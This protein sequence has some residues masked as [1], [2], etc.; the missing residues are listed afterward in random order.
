MKYRINIYSN[1]ILKNFL[2]NF[3]FEYELKFKKLDSIDKKQTNIF[4]NVII[5][6]NNK[7]LDLINFNK[8]GDNFLVISNSKKINS[9]QTKNTKFINSPISINHIRNTIENFIQNLKIK[10]HDICIDNEKLINLNNKFHC[11]LTKVEIEILSFLI[12]EKETS[13]NFIKENILK[14]K[15]DI[16][17][18]SLE[19]HLTRIRKKMI[20]IKTTVKIQ[21]KSEKLLITI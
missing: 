13:K 11:Y 21:S 7:D 20:K 3:L 14:I 12:R 19:S 10:F 17:T 6:S 18:N 15:S 8:L 4:A 2:T 9:F 16:E 1:I 5:I